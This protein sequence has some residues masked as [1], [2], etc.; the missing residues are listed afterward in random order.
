MAR[1]RASVASSK[2]LSSFRPKRIFTMWATEALGALPFP[3]TACLAFVGAY[4]KTG[5]PC[6]AAAKKAMPLAMPS[7]I[8]LCT[9]LSTNWV[10]TERISGAWIFMMQESSSKM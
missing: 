5:R 7:L 8:A 2:T 1:A 3:V 4:S 6:L 9:F 10:S